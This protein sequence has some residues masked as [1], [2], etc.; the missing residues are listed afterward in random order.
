MNK[1]SNRQKWEFFDLGLLAYDYKDKDYNKFLYNAYMLDKTLTMFDY[2]GL[3]DD[4]PKR[5]IEKALQMRGYAVIIKHNDKL[6]A[7]SRDVGL[8]GKL[9][10]YYRPTKAIISSPYLEIFKEYDIDRDCVLVRNDS[11]LLG[12]TPLNMIYSSQLVET[13]ISLIIALYN[14]RTQD[15]IAVPDDNTKKGADAYIESI[16]NGEMA[17]LQDNTFFDGIRKHSN[18]DNRTLSQL[19]EAKQ[20]IKASWLNELGLNANYNMKREA[21]NTTESQLNDDALLPFIDDMLNNRKEGVKRINEMFGTN[22]SVK[23][24]SSWE[25]R[26][27]SAQAETNEPDNTA[28]IT[29]SE[30]ITENDETN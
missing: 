25:L 29:E 17:S 9:D 10:M 23:L 14:S 1:I 22:I 13:D 30:V 28:E 3:P 2:D 26:K 5:E 8:G 19:I 24:S 18:A 20:Y 4:I 7:L 15:L 27:I 6:Y 11:L 21:L 16:I 12:L